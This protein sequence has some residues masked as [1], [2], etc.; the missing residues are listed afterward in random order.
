MI[1]RLALT[2]IAVALVCR[3]DGTR[4]VIG[5]Y[6]A[7]LAFRRCTRLLRRSDAAREAGRRAD[8]E[9][10]FARAEAVLRSAAAKD[11]FGQAAS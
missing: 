2:A 3:R 5:R 9:R 6:R 10:H 4:V 8:A 11:E 7:H 1:P